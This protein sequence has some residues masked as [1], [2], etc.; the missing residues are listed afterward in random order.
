MI[1][2]RDTLTFGIQIYPSVGTEVLNSGAVY[3][4]MDMRN[5]LDYNVEYYKLTCLS[6]PNNINEA[7]SRENVCL[8]ADMNQLILQNQTINTGVLKNYTPIS[9][10]DFTYSIETENIGNHKTKKFPELIIKNWN[11]KKLHFRIVDLTFN[12]PE[13]SI[14]RGAYTAYGGGDDIL[15]SILGSY[16]TTAQIRHIFRS[17]FTYYFKLEPYDIE[18]KSII[19]RPLTKTLC[20]VISSRDRDITKYQYGNEFSINLKPINGGYKYYK[21][22]ITSFTTRYHTSAVKNINN[23][24]KYDLF[25]YGLNKSKYGYGGFYNYYEDSY[26]DR[27]TYMGSFMTNGVGFIENVKLHNQLTNFN[28]NILTIEDDL[29]Y[30]EFKTFVPNGMKTYTERQFY[31]GVWY[32]TGV[33]NPNPLPNFTLEDGFEWLMV[34]NLYGFN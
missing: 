12:N 5:Y 16:F 21:A 33:V 11:S 1:I 10:T 32:E 17:G 31:N 2:T 34:L 18:T 30:V 20:M 27:A 29:G 22:L 26:D 13:E 14:I 6:Q 23:H 15:K 4:E 9:S 3:K 28:T 24:P 25:S 8:L 7:S 19:E